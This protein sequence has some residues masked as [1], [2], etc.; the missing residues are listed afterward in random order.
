MLD[1]L[2]RTRTLADQ[3]RDIIA[4]ELASGNPSILRASEH[5]R[6]S[7]R[8]LERRLERE[9]TT[10]SALLDELRRRLALGYVTEATLDL[11]E[12]ALLL[13]FSQTSAFHRAFKRWTGQTPL[14]YRRGQ[15]ELR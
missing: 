14:H 15:V 5:L 6:V 12:V 7:S 9:G 2:P 8:T 11:S 3:V 4:R 1:E 10:F 13:G